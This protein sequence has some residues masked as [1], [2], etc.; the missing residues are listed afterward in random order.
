MSVRYPLLN[1][2][3]DSY[4]TALLVNNPTAQTFPLGISSQAL[5]GHPENP[6]SDVTRGQ[7]LDELSQRWAAHK[8][9]GTTYDNQFYTAAAVVGSTHEETIPA[10]EPN[11]GLANP[12]GI[13]ATGN[14]LSGYP[15]ALPPGTPQAA[16]PLN[17]PPIPVQVLSQI[18]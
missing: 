12:G 13:A 18:V 4:L 11:A 8:I 9:N 6:F 10:G 17:G 3:T 2:L 14:A 1:R 5:A 16:A 7:L 15:A